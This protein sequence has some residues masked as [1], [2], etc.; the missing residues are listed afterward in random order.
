M[1]ATK[2]NLWSIE[3]LQGV[4]LVFS[5]LLKEQKNLSHAFTTRKGGKSLNLLGHLIWVRL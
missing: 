1:L 3:N 5:P 4:D 2:Y